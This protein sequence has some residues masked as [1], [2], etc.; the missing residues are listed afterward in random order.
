MNYRYILHKWDIPVEE[1]ETARWIKNE[2]RQQIAKESSGLGGSPSKLEKDAYDHFK[3][4]WYTKMAKQLGIRFCVSQHDAIQEVLYPGT[5][6]HEGPLYPTLAIS[7]GC[8]QLV[9]MTV[10]MEE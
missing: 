4:R 6:R 1:R 8:S 3:L 5:S 2:S 9:A 7:D 10:E